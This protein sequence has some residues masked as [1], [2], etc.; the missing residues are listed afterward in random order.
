L[1]LLITSYIP[2][3]TARST[4]KNIDSDHQTMPWFPGYFFWL[5]MRPILKL[6]LFANESLGWNPGWIAQAFL[7]FLLF[8]VYAQAALLIMLG[9]A[10]WPF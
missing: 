1:I 8:L 4:I 3:I 5:F 6:M 2:I 7:F 10:E 9:Y